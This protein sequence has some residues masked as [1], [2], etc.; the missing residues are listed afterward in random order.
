MRLSFPARL[1]FINRLRIYLGENSLVHIM[2]RS[3]QLVPVRLLALFA[4]PFVLFLAGVLGG[5]T[6][7]EAA[8]VRFEALQPTNAQ[9]AASRNVARSLE[10]GHYRGLRL[11]KDLSSK[12]FDNY[13]KNLDNQRIYLLASDVQE[14]EQ[15]RYR[16]DVALKSGQL[17]AAF[18]IYNRFQMR[19][20]ERLQYLLGRIDAGL[21]KIDLNQREY[22]LIDRSEEPWIKTRDEMDRLWDKRL[23]SAILTLKLSG[24]KLDEI[25]DTLKKRYQSQLNKALQTKSEDVF[26]VYMNAFTGVYDPHT[27]Y[28]SPRVSENFNINMSLSLEGI[29]AVLQSDNDYTKVVRLVP[30]GPADKG[31]Q[32]KPSDR[33]IGVGQGESGEIVDVVGWRLE[34]VVDLIRGPKRSTVRLQIIPANNENETRIISI[35]RDQV[36]LEEQAAQK[37]LVKVYR[38]GRQYKVGII[39]IP[40]FYADFRAMQAGNPNYRSTTRDVRRLI[41]SLKEEGID[42]LIIDLRNN[43]GG[44]LQEA[45]SLSGLF[46]AGGPTVQVRTADQNVRVYE[47]PAADVA[48]DGPLA[49]MVNRMSAS[50]SEIFAGAIQD[51]GRGLILGDQTFGKGTV[52]SVRDLVHGQLKITEAKFYRIS[53][54][55]TQ[56]KGVIPD[57][58]YPTIIDRNE[59]GEDALPEALAWDQIKGVAYKPF[60]GYDKFL[61]DL[62]QRHDQR[63]ASSEEYQL[64]LDEI[65]LVRETRSQKLLSLNEAE[66]KTEKDALQARQLAIVNKRRQLHGEPPFK[67]FEELEKFEEQRASE[68]PAKNQEI[69]FLARE[70]GE[71]L[72]DLIELSQQMVAQQDSL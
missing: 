15:Y 39:T 34:E 21:D 6:Q 5:A 57:I 45:I 63:M 4:I 52:Q 48:Y 35:V 16:L 43:G 38:N 62:R 37:D 51:Y 32:L 68:S 66:R 56:H 64:L 8:G 71:I 54:A 59:I 10:F 67:N 49:V 22:M 3:L 2:M 9:M 20:V 27:Q 25:E 50:A 29:G 30:A 55:S 61:Q 72:V 12:I 31:G 58:S 70:S 65:E 44:S 60:S 17:D 14:F 36:K 11:D 42:G 26:Q 13:L 19:L 47:D 69:D 24:K 41:D 18:S 23:K 46:I 33:I 7:I 53:G 40:T 28:F 1:I